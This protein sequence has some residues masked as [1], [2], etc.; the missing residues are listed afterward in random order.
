MTERSSALLEVRGLTV[1]ADPRALL[2]DGVDLTL[3]AGESLALVGPSGSGKSLTARALLGLLP[4][5]LPWTGTIAWDG[6]A[7]TDPTGPEWREVRGRGLGL[8]MQEPQAALNPVL[9]VGDQV[10]EALRLRGGVP[11]AEADARAVALLAELQ[12]PEPA[13]TARRYP[14]ELSGGM[15]QRVL[16]AATLAC[17]PRLLVADEPTTA[18]DV[19]VQRDILL[20]LRQVGRERGMGLLFI[21]HDMDLVPL[22]ADNCVVMDAGRAGPV[23]SVADLVRPGPPP[24]LVVPAEAAPVLTVRDLHVRYRGAAQHAVAGVDLDLRPGR[25]VGLLGRS[26]CGKTS[27]GRALAGHVPTTQGTITPA[28]QDRAARRRVQML[29]QDPG[30]SLNPRQT[31][32][33]AL[34]EAAGPAGQEVSALLAE[35][36]L[37]AEL[38]DRLPHRLSGGQR[39][40]VALARCL[41]TAPAVLI[42]DEPT[43]A[44]DRAA[45]DR[46]LALLARIGRQRGLALLLIS[47]D[48]GVLRRACHEVQVMVGGLIVE[49]LPTGVG[50][51]PRH[52]YT[53]DLMGASP[54]A[55]REDPEGWGSRDFLTGHAVGSA[56]SGC[57]LYGHCLLQKPICGKELPSLKTAGANHLLR[58]PEAETEGPSHFIDTI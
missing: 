39:Q 23:Q 30:G 15:R 38:Q 56:G 10:A 8:V 42:A 53:R 14:H 40:R 1:G 36:G 49:V 35:V 7:L 33:Q 29:F 37:A 52:P 20:L 4:P 47:H 51:R 24:A 19:A 22:L 25:S 57:P 6:R 3:A 54:D 34:A 31:V 2:L 21:T 18:L 5:D 27:L 46:V 48:I 9:R 44:L 50:C 26:G 13:R 28:P 43:S 17:G 32:G 45:A 12:V 16:L 58:C 41:A 11:A 55:L